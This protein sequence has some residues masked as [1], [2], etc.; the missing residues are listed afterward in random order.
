M[1]FSVLWTTFSAINLLETALAHCVNFFVVQIKEVGTVHSVF[2]YK[3]PV[4][5][6]RA[7]QILDG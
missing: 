2:F 4:Y 3:K 5:K 1:Y 7:P 6:K